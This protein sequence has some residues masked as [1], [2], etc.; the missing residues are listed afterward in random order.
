[1]RGIEVVK[2]K[3]RCAPLLSDSAWTTAIVLPYLDQSL[4]NNRKTE[5]ECQNFW[6]RPLCM[7]PCEGAVDA[8]NTDA[9]YNSG[10]VA[11]AAALPHPQ[12]DPTLIK[13]ERALC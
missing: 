9:E 13:L 6:C 3:V 12:G 5:S 8:Y 1:M 10:D 11:I 4:A 7:L 2:E